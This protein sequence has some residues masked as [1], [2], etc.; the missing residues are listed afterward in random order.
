M[1]QSQHRVITA[2][3]AATAA[4]S[5]ALGLSAC[6]SAPVP[7]ASAPAI[8]TPQ[9]ALAGEWIL[10]RTV[11]VSNV[12]TDPSRVVG[13]VSTRLVSIEQSTCES[14]ICPGTVSS[15]VTAEAR[16]TTELTQTDGGLE[17]TFAGKLNCLNVSSGEVHVAD[18]FTFDSIST[19]TVTESADVD[20]SLSATLLEG[21]MVLNDTLSIEAFNQGC[22]RDPAEAHVEYT[23]SAVRAPA[24]VATSAP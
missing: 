18:A 11:T 15:G 24:A 5:L 16:E 20:G 9:A 7:V 3:I 22:R 2:A 21:V 10:T 13:A 8:T 23:L 1:N 17:W 12:L 14:A 6:G 4:V 19:L